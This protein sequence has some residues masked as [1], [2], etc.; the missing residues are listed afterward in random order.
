MPSATCWRRTARIWPA[1][2][3]GIGAVAI[4]IAA[5]AVYGAFQKQKRINEE[6]QRRNNP[7]PAVTTPARPGPSHG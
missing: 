1:V 6:Q 2:I 4:V 7:Q 3:A 5:I